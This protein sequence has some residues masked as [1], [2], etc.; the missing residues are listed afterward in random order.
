[1]SRVN[2]LRQQPGVCT[3]SPPDRRIR[4]VSCRLSARPP[5]PLRRPGKCLDEVHGRTSPIV[6]R[7]RRGNG[8]S[9]ISKVSAIAQ[10][11]THLR[12]SFFN[13]GCMHGKRIGLRPN[14]GFAAIGSPYILCASR[15]N[16]PQNSRA[17]F[18]RSQRLSD[19]RE[20][21]ERELLLQGG[22]STG[23]LHPLSCELVLRLLSESLRVRR[24]SR[25]SGAG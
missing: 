14:M 22:H 13:L 7:A 9:A 16:V 11:S 15:Q 25:P 18:E 24:G 10:C 3:S 23:L 8:Y 21:E 17:A 20:R 2:S 1:M 12:P 19:C 4:G 5:L 6:I